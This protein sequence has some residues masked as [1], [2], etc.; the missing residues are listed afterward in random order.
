MGEAIFPERPLR[1]ASDRQGFEEDHAAEGGFLTYLG[2]D[3]N[4]SRFHDAGRREV[5]HR[6]DAKNVDKWIDTFQE[7][8]GKLEAN[9]VVTYRDIAII[10]GIMLWDHSMSLS[11]KSSPEIRTALQLISK[12]GKEMYEELCG[13]QGRFAAVDIWD[14][15][16][17]LDEEEVSTLLAALESLI[18]DA[19]ERLD[20]NISLKKR[21][22]IFKQDKA[23]VRLRFYLCSDSSKKK[24]AGV[25]P[26][27]GSQ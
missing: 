3:Y 8:S 22:H 2:V 21:F 19:V 16:C 10:V 14:D 24:A 23:F 13:K 12:N 5:R 6:H 25:F 15:P 4:T 17:H 11:P 7:I 26:S 1:C 9:E 18:E 27:G 20:T